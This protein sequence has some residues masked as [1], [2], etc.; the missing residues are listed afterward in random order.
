MKKILFP[1]LVL[2]L[3]VLACTRDNFVPS[4]VDCSDNIAPP[5]Y[6]GEMQALID[7]NCA[8]AECHDGN[9]PSVPGD[10][11]TY[12]GLRIHFG[13]L[14]E[15]RVILRIEDPVLGMPPDDANGPTDL[16]EEHLAL[17]SCWIDAEFPEN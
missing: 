9:T 16:T 15:E 4:A 8:Y 3:L 13:G 1:S 10:Y 5:T 17:F 6:D 2:I 12:E 7:L 14:I 11:T